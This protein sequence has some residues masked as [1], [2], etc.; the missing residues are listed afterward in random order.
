MNCDIKIYGDVDSKN[1]VI[2]YELALQDI[3]NLYIPYRRLTNKMAKTQMIPLVNLS[4][5][6][7][8]NQSS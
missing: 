1:L 7:T 8:S 5:D 3:I 6:T 2:S 4:F